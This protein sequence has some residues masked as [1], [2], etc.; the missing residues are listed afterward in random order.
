MV[1]LKAERLLAARGEAWG[2][3]RNLTT[4]DLAKFDRDAELFD[5]YLWV[6]AQIDSLS[7]V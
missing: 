7:R 3:S 1:K 4:F 5:N 6:F 2:R